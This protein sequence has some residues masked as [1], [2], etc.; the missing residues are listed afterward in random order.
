M[1]DRAR[2]LLQTF[3]SGESVA[4]AAAA[5]GHAPPALREIEYGRDARQK[6]D[7]YPAPE[8]NGAVIFLVH[9]GGWEEGDKAKSSLVDHKVAYWRPLGYT[10][11]STNYRLEPQAEPFV[12]AEDIA[13]AIAFA[14][15][16]AR[17]WGADPGRFVL[18][19]HSAGAHLVALLNASSDIA[20]A[21]GCRPWIGSVLLDCTI[22][23]V[24]AVMSDPDHAEAYDAFGS[25]PVHWKRTSPLDCLAGATPP[26]LL[27]QST[28]KGKASQARIFADKARRL[29][30]DA[31][32]LEE[33]LSHR[34]IDALLGLPGRYTED[35]AAFV[36]RV[37][38][39]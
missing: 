21:A 10:L 8:P 11:V 20:R 32:V 28:E 12:Q 17:A 37:A 3:A 36:E 5:P 7:V 23:D 6:F 1:L 35:V 29:G 26:M 31:T 13:R 14:Q 25:D 30:S 33:D 4:A 27:V 19:G 39:A 18:M 9:G 34:D 24:A 15:G 2:H 16:E 22:Y 38:Q